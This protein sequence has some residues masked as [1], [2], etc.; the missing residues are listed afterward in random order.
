MCG[1]R[2]TATTLQD[3]ARIAHRLR[4]SCDGELLCV[5]LDSCSSL[6]SSVQS[7]FRKIDN[8]MPRMLLQNAVSLRDH[9]H[10]SRSCRSCQPLVTSPSL[11]TLHTLRLVCS[12]IEHHTA[13]TM[14][15]LATNTRTIRARQENNTSSNLTR[16]ARASNRAR[17]LLLLLNAHGTR[18]QWR[19]HRARSNGVDADVLGDELV[20]EAAGE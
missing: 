4:G 20:C 16:L 17:K 11:D 9:E 2:V 7:C 10:A 1:S 12:N 15:N 14:N 8:A 19:P 18:D 13:I 3:Q 6:Q 5:M